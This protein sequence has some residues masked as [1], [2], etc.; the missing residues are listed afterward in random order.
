MG[1]G[2]R[3]SPRH[4][5]SQPLPPPARGLASEQAAEHPHVGTRK[6]QC[7]SLP[8]PRPGQDFKPQRRHLPGARAVSPP[9]AAAQ[10]QTA[11]PGSLEGRGAPRFPAVCVV[12]ASICRCTRARQPVQPATEAQTRREIPG[13]R[14]QLPEPE[15]ASHKNSCGHALGRANA[16]GDKRLPSPEICLFLTQI[17]SKIWFILDVIRTGS[18]LP[19]AG[20]GCSRLC[21]RSWDLGWGPANRKL[22]ITFPR[23]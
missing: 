17:K 12:M 1:P 10:Q 5:T 7:S 6:R 22:N 19:T 21:G 2:I 9:R 8:L 15:R 4:G 16:P 13:E 20:R 14:A 18:A 11:E 3:D 23:P